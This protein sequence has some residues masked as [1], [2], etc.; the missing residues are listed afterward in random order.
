MRTIGIALI[1]LLLAGDAYASDMLERESGS[2]DPA[3]AEQL[4]LPLTSTTSISI[5]YLQFDLDSGPARHALT[6]TT[7][8][9]LWHDPSQVETIK[10][11]VSV[12]LPQ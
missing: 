4:E 5:Q 11:G 7:D 9:F 6:P 8:S 12:K 10:L 3:V 1:A 2:A